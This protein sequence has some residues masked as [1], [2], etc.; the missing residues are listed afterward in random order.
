MS[1][2]IFLTRFRVTRRYLP[3]ASCS[4]TMAPKSCMYFMPDNNPVPTGYKYVNEAFGL[5]QTS[6]TKSWLCHWANYLNLLNPVSSLQSGR[7]NTCSYL[8]LKTENPESQCR[9]DCLGTRLRPKHS[10]TAKYCCNCPTS[11]FLV[12][13]ILVHSQMLAPSF[14]MEPQ[15][16]PLHWDFSLMLGD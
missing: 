4:L 12:L 5:T 2:V 15:L 6:W 9:A 7:D 13:W 1:H 10:S 11:G 16:L 3:L 14:S 8:H